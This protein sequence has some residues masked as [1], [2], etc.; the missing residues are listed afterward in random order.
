MCTAC[1]PCAEAAAA[2]AQR[3]LSSLPPRECGPSAGGPGRRQNKPALFPCQGRAGLGQPAAGRLRAWTGASPAVPRP[4]ELRTSGERDGGRGAVRGWGQRAAPGTSS[5]PGRGFS[6]KVGFSFLLVWHLMKLA[7]QAW[8]MGEGGL[9]RP[10]GALLA[11]AHPGFSPA[12]ALSPEAGPEL[13]LCC[14][15]WPALW[16]CPA[17]RDPCRTLRRPQEQKRVAVLVRAP[18]LPCASPPQ[19]QF[20]HCSPPTGPTRPVSKHPVLRVKGCHWVSQPGGGRCRQDAPRRPRGGR[21]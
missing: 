20:W 13:G 16:T 3:H 7:A 11:G 15:Q 19:A 21:S 4:E 9:G 8:K 18:A 17:Q 2:S 1:V 5:G 6:R 14:R 10:T 12:S